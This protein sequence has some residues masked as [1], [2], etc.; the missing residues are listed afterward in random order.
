NGPIHRRLRLLRHQFGTPQATSVSEPLVGVSLHRARH[1]MVRIGA[2]RISRCVL[3]RN[4]RPN[5]VE[6]NVIPK[7][8]TKFHLDPD[9]SQVY[10]S[11]PSKRGQ[12]FT[13]LSSVEYAINTTCRYL[14]RSCIDDEW[15][16]VS[17]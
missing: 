3:R 15:V 2:F 16:S 8:W 12:T 13:S 9:E 10:V 1:S 11:C 5:P 7:F 6:I 14:D 4:R 17:A